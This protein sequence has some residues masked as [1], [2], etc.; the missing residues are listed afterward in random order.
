LDGVWAAEEAIAFPLKSVGFAAE[1]ADVAAHDIAATAGAEV[2]VH[3][4]DTDS[5]EDLA[6][7]P[8][9]RYLK[10]WLAIDD[11]EGLT[12]ALPSP[13]VP[14]LTYL[15]RDFSAGWRRES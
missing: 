14:V 2:E 10:A 11:D 15:A 7:L 4:F 13:G 9:G 12:T 6:G 1:Q 5:R 3:A 8:A